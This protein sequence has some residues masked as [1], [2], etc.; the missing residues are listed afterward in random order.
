MNKWWIFLIVFIVLIVVGACLWSMFSWLG[1]TSSSKKTTSTAKVLS[2]LTG[3]NQTDCLTNGC[4][5]VQQTCYGGKCCNTRD[6]IGGLIEYLED[7]GIEGFMQEA[8]LTPDSSGIAPV[9]PVVQ[10]TNFSL[11]VYH[12][13]VRVQFYLSP[14]IGIPGDTSGDCTV[15][16]SACKGFKDLDSNGCTFSATNS[17]SIITDCQ[18]SLSHCVGNPDVCIPWTSKHDGC[19]CTCKQS[20]VVVSPPTYEIVDVIAYPA[21]NFQY[22]D[23]GFGAILSAT[24]SLKNFAFWG[25]LIGN[26]TNGIDG[27]G[28]YYRGNVVITF[29]ND[30]GIGMNI[31]INT[32]PSKGL[33]TVMGLGLNSGDIKVD[34]T[35]IQWENK[36]DLGSVIEGQ[37]LDTLRDSVADSIDKQVKAFNNK[38]LLPPKDLQ[39]IIDSAMKDAVSAENVSKFFT[40]FILPISVNLDLDIVGSVTISVDPKSVPKLSIVKTAVSSTI[41]VGVTFDTA[42]NVNVV[43]DS[44]GRNVCPLLSRSEANC[45]QIPAGT[46][47]TWEVSLDGKANHKPKAFWVVLKAFTVD[48]PT[49]TLVIDAL[50]DPSIAAGIQASFDL[51]MNAFYG[52]QPV[53]GSKLCKETSDCPWP[54]VCTGG[55]CVCAHS[56]CPRLCS[57]DNDCS[58][59]YLDN[60]VGINYTPDPVGGI[61]FNVTPSVSQGLSSTSCNESGVCS[62]TIADTAT[63]CTNDPIKECPLLALNGGFQQSS[64]SNSA[65][66]G[67]IYTAIPRENG[68]NPVY[69]QECVDSKCHMTIPPVS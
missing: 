30:K 37:I 54:H 62:Q 43:Q 44:S 34:T 36:G 40:A 56:E 32:D 60:A 12:I 15:A 8:L 65:R 19:V 59:Y 17:C 1:A 53:S 55:M 46:K 29:E 35:G 63:S 67:R 31:G 26:S 4:G 9:D 2:H 38:K 11:D 51:L 45:S 23:D 25:Y 28:M 13:H 66:Y 52:C 24:M 18:K 21:R 20:P 39:G 49:D 33:L 14:Y 48:S 5:G 58:T 16:T 41:T 7:G 6:F 50:N 47:L 69:S 64:V 42:V 68:K 10:G 3:G 27:D 22:E 57:S 61:M